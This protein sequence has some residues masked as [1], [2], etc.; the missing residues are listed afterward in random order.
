M[1]VPAAVV[2]DAEATDRQLHGA[3]TYGS[4]AAAVDRSPRQAA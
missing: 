3:A 1:V 2:R 4:K